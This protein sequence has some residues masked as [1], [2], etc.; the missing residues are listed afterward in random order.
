MANKDFKVKN[1]IDVATPIPVSM[2]GTGQTSTTNTLNSLLPA[3]NGNANKVLQ[4]DGTNTTWYT[5]PAAY[6]TGGMASRPASPTAGD[7]FFNTDKKAFEVW[8]GSAWVSVAVNGAVPLAPTVGTVTVSGLTASVPFTGSNDYGDSAVTTNT[9]T[10]VEDAT[11]TASS[12]TSPIS[13]TGLTSSTSYTFTVTSTNAFGV[14]NASSASNSITTASTPGAPTSVTASDPGTDGY[15]LVSWTAPA[16]NGGSAITDYTVQYSSNS[17]SSW[18]TFSDGTSASTS[19]T[20]TGLTLNTAYIFRVA[21]VNALGTG[22]YSDPSASF[23]PVAHDSG[24]MFPLQVITVGPAGASSVEFTSIPATYTH[25]QIRYISRSENAS[26][27]TTIMRINSDTGNNY[28]THRLYGNGS[29]AGSEGQNTVSFTELPRTAYGATGSNIFGG[30]VIDILDYLNTNKYKTIRVLGGC[31]ENGS[32][33]VTFVSGL[34]QSTSAIT[35]V[36]FLPSGGADMAEY[37]T[38]ALYGIKGA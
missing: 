2:G 33:A 37:T 16:S 1:G 17:G 13:V 26:D 24:A 28:S 38:F 31:D 32:G 21:A 8:T 18:T 23:T 27:S 12:S 36:N 25:L 35:A 3:Q 29:A 10:A 5:V 14:S 6:T 19:A 30:G 34:W 9:A 15:A 7:L 4:T 20:V 11:K 22:S